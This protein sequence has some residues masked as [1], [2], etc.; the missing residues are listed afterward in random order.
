MLQLFNFPIEIMTHIISW[1][2]TFGKQL[3][4]LIG[5]WLMINTTDSDFVGL[6]LSHKISTLINVY[7]A[8]QPYSI[9][10]ADGRG[11]KT[12][13]LAEAKWCPLKHAHTH[14][15]TTDRPFFTFSITFQTCRLD[16]GS[17]PVVGSSRIKIS[18]LPMHAMATDRRL[19]MPPDSALDLQL[20]AS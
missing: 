3:N 7:I 17:S 5:T 4:A 8:S 14:T 16:A 15:H 18:G 11:V 12:P 13:M 9:A 6:D 10:W 2:T 19:L 20:R 1:L